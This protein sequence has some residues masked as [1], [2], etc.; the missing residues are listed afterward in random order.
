[1][2]SKWS[3]GLV[4]YGADDTVFLVVDRFH[5]GHALK[6]VMRWRGQRR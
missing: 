1:M 6:I 3:P 4:P 5:L 2:P